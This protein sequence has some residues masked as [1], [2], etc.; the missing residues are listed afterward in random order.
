MFLD[1]AELGNG[2]VVGANA[3]ITKKI[4]GQCSSCRYT[5]ESNKSQEWEIGKYDI[6]GNVWKIRESV[7]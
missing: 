5:S 6:Y 4:P 1:G 2:C 3:V 7:F